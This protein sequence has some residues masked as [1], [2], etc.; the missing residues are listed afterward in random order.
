MK[1]A[2][3]SDTFEQNNGVA[4][5]IKQVLPFL[6]KKTSVVLYTGR[7]NGSY[8]FQTRALPFVRYPM[9]P[10]YDIVIPPGKIPQVDVVHAHSPYTLGLYASALDLPKVVTAHFLPYHFIESIFGSKQPGTITNAVWK[11]ESWFLNR[12]DRVISQTNNGA[13]IFRR[14][15]VKKPIDVV[16][17]GVNLEEFKKVSDNLFRK[18]YGIKKDY[19]VFVGRYDS[20][21]QPE[22]VLQCARALPTRQFVMIGAGMQ[23]KKLARKAPPNVKMLPRIPREQVLSAYKGATVTLMPSKIET[24]GLVAQESQACG[25]P[26]LYTPLKVLTEVVGRGGEACSTPSKMAIATRTLFENPAM[27]QEMSQRALTQV[28]KRDI[29][30]SV[31]KLLNIYEKIA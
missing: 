2:W 14:N 29:N 1:T 13:A 25:T 26:V 6:A 30:A 19:A 27:R 17:N 22:W 3:F 16:P 8:P 31:E 9:I 11:Y 7:V 10:D 20:S 15:G 12:F 21:K 28:K 23:T 4:T 18:K 5:A 24:E